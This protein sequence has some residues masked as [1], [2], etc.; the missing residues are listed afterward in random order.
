MDS[1][2]V[3]P[4]GLSVIKEVMNE[5]HTLIRDYNINI[6]KNTIIN[7]TEL[8]KEVYTEDVTK[9]KVIT[10]SIGILIAYT[11]D[12]SYTVLV[13]SDNSI[14]KLAPVNMTDT[15]GLLDVDMTKFAYL[16]KCTFHFNKLYL[17]NQL[18]MI[19]S[20]EYEYEIND[21]LE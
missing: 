20:F 14:E 21:E 2:K 12:K 5:L 3:L 1:V 19:P 9:F 17:P 6:E 13:F 4:K 8:I 10:S 15:L 18:D 11:N 16:S 7:V